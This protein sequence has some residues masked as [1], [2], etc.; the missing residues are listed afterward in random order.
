MNL[1]KPNEVFSNI[2]HFVF[3]IVIATSY[4]T[5]AQIFINPDKPFLS[6][7]STIIPGLELLLAYITI[8]SGWV[9][10][11]RS[12]A[13]WPH[14]NTKAGTF[15]F[16]LDIAILFCY[17]GLIASADTQNGFRDYFLNWILALF[18]L[19]IVWDIFKMK[20][21]FGKTAIVRQQA[22]FRSLG[23][24]IAFTVLFFFLFV[25]FGFSSA[26]QIGIITGDV[27]YG[28]FLIAAM[29]LMLAYRYLKWSI[30]PQ[31]RNVGS[32][33]SKKHTAE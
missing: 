21:Y 19:F 13:K 15:R 14:K 3:A 5:A 20:E 33:H 12:M 11:S 32:S 22:L 6:D 26:I 16:S 17:F 9:G 25:F 24:S 10:Y 23:K 8:V 4:N 28:I 18:F 31:K 1:Q 29:F 30:P 27:V 7:S 2:C